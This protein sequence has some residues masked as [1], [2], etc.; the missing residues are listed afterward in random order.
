MYFF[1][2]YS[3]SEDP[4]AHISIQTTSSG[5][6]ESLLFVTSEMRNAFKLYPEVLLM[7]GTYRINKYRMPLYTFIIEDGNGNGRV[8]EFCFVSTE[9]KIVIETLLQEMNKV[10]K[11]LLLLTKTLTR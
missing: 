10:Q 6:L 8:V 11:E 4:D 9:K 3:G 2:F 1:S 7:D 5:E